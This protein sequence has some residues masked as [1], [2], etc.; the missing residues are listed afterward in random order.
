MKGYCLFLF[1][2][3]LGCAKAEPAKIPTGKCVTNGDCKS[4]LKCNQMGYCEDIY[5]PEVSTGRPRLEY[6]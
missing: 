2:G 4:G 6:R 5:H 1:I 3:L